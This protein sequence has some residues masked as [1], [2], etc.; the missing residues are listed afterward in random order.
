MFLFGFFAQ[1]NQNHFE[2]HLECIEAC[3]DSHSNNKTL[4][5]SHALVTVV[6]VKYH[7]FPKIELIVDKMQLENLK[8]KRD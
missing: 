8:T 3:S 2:W 6:K 1:S 7:F 4:P 5:I